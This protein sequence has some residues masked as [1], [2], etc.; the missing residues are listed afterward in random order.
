MFCAIG[1]GPAKPDKLT[2]LCPPEQA[3]VP[4]LLAARPPPSPRPSPLEASVPSPQARRALKALA[5]AVGSKRKALRLL[6]KPAL[7]SLKKFYVSA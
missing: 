3:T 5:A 6:E 1:V 2:S 4:A 7:V